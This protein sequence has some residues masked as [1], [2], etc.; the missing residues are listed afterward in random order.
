MRFT[1]GRPLLLLGL[2]VIV[3]WLGSSF[4]R[5][6]P[7][8]LGVVMRFGAYSYRTEP[9]LHWHL[10]WPIENVLLPAV[11]RINRT[12]IGYRSAPAGSSTP[13]V[14]RP[15]ATCRPRA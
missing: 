9:G 5:V 6:Q 13:A 14:T 10:P 4:Y 11:T 15:G 8:E 3:L 7:D 1:G 2:V 12:E